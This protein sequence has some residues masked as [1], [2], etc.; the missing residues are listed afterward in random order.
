MVVFD[1]VIGCDSSEGI[2]DD[3][4]VEE[5][6]H[7]VGGCVDAHPVVVWSNDNGYAGLVEKGLL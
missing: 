6:F 3:V 1:R 5:G 7:T 2:V 4:V